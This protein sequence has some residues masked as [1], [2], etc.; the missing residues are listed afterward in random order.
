MVRFAWKCWHLVQGFCPVRLPFTKHE[1]SVCAWTVTKRFLIF[2]FLI[3]VIPKYSNHKDPLPSY[4]AVCG[5][6]SANTA[7]LTAKFL[8]NSAV[9]TAKI[10]WKLCCLNRESFLQ[11]M[12]AHPWKFPANNAGLTACAGYSK[13]SRSAVNTLSKIREGN[14]KNANLD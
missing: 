10:P 9:L 12:L 2:Y 5:H 3:L 1:Q 11:I 6:F 4:E 8:A 13:F 7:A 14:I